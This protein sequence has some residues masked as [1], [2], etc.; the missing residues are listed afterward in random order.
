MSISEAPQYTPTAQPRFLQIKPQE[1]VPPARPDAFARLVR[2]SEVAGEPDISVD[3]FTQDALDQH[4]HK[5]AAAVGQ[6]VEPQFDRLNVVAGL[7]AEKL[8]A[9]GVD[10]KEVIEEAAAKQAASNQ[11]K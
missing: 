4:G 8:Q 3:V 6:I 1:V 7:F 11:V 5:C 10:P 9:L 2:K